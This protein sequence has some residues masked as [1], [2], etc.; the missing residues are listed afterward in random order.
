MSQTH[1]NTIERQTNLKIERAISLQME[2]IIPKMQ[3][4]SKSYRI[5][6][7]KEKSPFRNVLN[8]ATDPGSGIEVTK[9]Y[10]RYQLGRR[11]ANRMWQET[12]GGDTTFATALVEKIDALSTD[13]E[14]ILKSVAQDSDKEP[15]KTQIQKVHL[16]L[17]QLYLGNL[18]RYQAYLAN[19][20]DNN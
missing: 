9:N 19:E 11:G 15:D 17:M 6:N 13:A 12:A 14:K 1:K 2:E 3:D 5:A 18:A 20:R 7:V 8:V 10:I 16:R 4:F